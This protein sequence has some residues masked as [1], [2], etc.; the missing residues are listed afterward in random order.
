MMAQT[1]GDA[2]G[3][4]VASLADKWIQRLGHGTVN[5]R[6][7]LLLSSYVNLT[8]DLDCRRPYQKARTGRDLDP[9]AVFLEEILFLFGEFIRD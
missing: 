2:R 5:Q 1:E 3:A 6:H 7:G 4:P 8:E 9:D